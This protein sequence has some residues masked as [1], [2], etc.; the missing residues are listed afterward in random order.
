MFD[1]SV[2]AHIRTTEAQSEVAQQ[3]YRQTVFAAFEEVENALVNLDAHKKQRRELQEQNAH[4]RVVAAQIEAQLKEG[5]V[6][7][8]EVLESERSLAAAE[9]ALVR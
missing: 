8:L 9:L 6:S 2:K 3:Q 4:L 5:V 1:P 7:Q